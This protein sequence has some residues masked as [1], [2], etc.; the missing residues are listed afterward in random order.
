[1]QFTREPGDFNNHIINAYDDH[2]VMIK[3][4]RYEHSVIITPD[5]IIDNWSPQN[6]TELALEHVD[7]LIALKPE[8]VILGV[9]PQLQFPPAQF[10]THLNQ[11]N[12]GIEVMTTA[13]AC[14]TFNV[15]LGEGRNVI[16]ALLLHTPAPG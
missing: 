1:M 16:A 6:L 14:R 3:A 10:I 4:M 7:A 13:A 5:K 2:H 12:I 9:G 8:I 15:L 11:A